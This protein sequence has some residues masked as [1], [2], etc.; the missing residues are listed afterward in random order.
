MEHRGPAAIERMGERDVGVPPLDRMTTQR[1]RVQRGRLHT[2][3]VDRRTAVVHE[4]R[5]RQ[6]LRAGASPDNVGRLH[7]EHRRPR[8]GKANGSHQSVRPGADHDRV[9]RG[10]IRGLGHRQIMTR[11]RA[12]C[13]GG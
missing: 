11:S 12:A 8:L 9:V 3:R 7:H 5:Q 1:R 2:E 10:S 13:T 6:W 4:P